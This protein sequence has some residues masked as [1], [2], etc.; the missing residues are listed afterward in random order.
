M[1]STAATADR[2]SDC[3]TCPSRRPW[4]RIAAAAVAAAL[5][6]LPLPA[7]AASADRVE[8]KWQTLVPAALTSFTPSKA[9]PTTGAFTAVGSTE[10]RG[11]WIGVTTYTMSGTIDLL[12]NESSGV[13]Q[14]TFIGT[15]G[16]TPAA[17]GEVGTLML[18]EQF[19]L[20][21]DGDLQIHCRIVGGA[22]RFAESRGHVDFEGQMLSV[23]EGSGTY[24]GAW[25]HA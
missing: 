16:G 21:V 17:A 10:W 8:G 7:H 24:A 11:T 1:S 18:T 3:A 6:L 15:T 23:V 25:K 9:N 4:A 20:G 19:T 2:Q 5:M 22:G 14:E 12:T 13:L